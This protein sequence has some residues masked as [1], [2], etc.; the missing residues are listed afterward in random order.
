MHR[1]RLAG[2][3]SSADPV[4]FLME[5][6]EL[7]PRGGGGLAGLYGSVLLMLCTVMASSRS[8][9]E[10]PRRST[11]R[12]T[13]AT[14]R[15]TRI[16]HVNIRNLAGVPS[17]VYGLLGLAIFV[18]ALGFLTGVTG[19]PHGHLRW[20]DAR[21]ARAADRHHHNGRRRCGRSRAGSA[22]ARYGVGATQWETTRHHVLPAA[23]G[24]L[25]GTVLSLAR[26]FGEAAPLLLVGGIT[27]SSSRR[28]GPRRAD[29]S[30]PVHRAA[31]WSSSAGRAPQ[32]GAHRG[33]DRRDAGAAAAINATG[34]YLR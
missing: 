21:S 13:R 24:I 22:R 9:W 28:A 2:A 16:V 27:T 26:A 11:S 12:S 23:P 32:E 4:D 30:G 17:I 8:R 18:K 34:I 7:R 15:F 19:G 31:R 25:T 14:A 5:S 3:A 33:L 1:R 29:L 20:S 10:S 6:A